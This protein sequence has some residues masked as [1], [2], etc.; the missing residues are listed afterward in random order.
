MGNI[1]C[2]RRNGARAHSLR[3]ASNAFCPTRLLCVLVRA[4]LVPSCFLLP[5]AVRRGSSR[6]CGSSTSGWDKL[7]INAFIMIIIARKS[8]WIL[9]PLLLHIHNP[10]RR[11]RLT[12][13]VLVVVIFIMFGW[14]KKKAQAPE[15]PVVEEP[16]VPRLDLSQVICGGSS[17]RRGA[18]GGVEGLNARTR[19]VGGV[20]ACCVTQQDMCMCF[21]FCA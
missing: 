6:V 15:T 18:E 19:R 4:Q 17:G 21:C 8:K 7:P 13:V 9:M 14:G 1:W 16:K 5:L 3:F 12:A 20:K 2:E 11:L 10:H